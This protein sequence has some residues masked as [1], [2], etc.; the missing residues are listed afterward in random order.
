MMRMVRVVLSNHS[1]FRIALDHQPEEIVARVEPR[2]G[3][4]FLRHVLRIR[5]LR[6]GLRRL[7]SSR[8]SGGRITQSG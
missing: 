1:T 5:L 3:F 8:Y 6:S 7:S 4:A 2:I